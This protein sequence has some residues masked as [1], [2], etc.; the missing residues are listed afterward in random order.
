MVT[1]IG[2]TNGL[3]RAVSTSSPS[4]ALNTEMAGVIMA[5]ANSSAAPTRPRKMNSG[6]VTDSLRVR[7]TTS[8]ISARMP[9][10]PRLSARRMKATYSM[11]MTRMRT[12]KITDRTP[13]TLASST[14]SA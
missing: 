4:T 7:P 10:S 9:P 13:R 14:A 6:L 12:Q 2:T 3:N 5:S 1:A 11:E 8:A